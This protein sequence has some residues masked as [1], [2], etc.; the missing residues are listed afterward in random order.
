MHWIDTH[1]HLYDAQFAEDQAAM[2]ARAVAAGVTKMYLPN[3][4]LGSIPGMLAIE[5]AYP[6]HCHAL[7]GLHPCS[8][9][10]SYPTVL[11]EMAAWLTQRPFVAIGEI[12]LDFYWDKTY[13]AEQEAAFLAQLEWAA[14]YNLPIVIHSRESTDRLVELLRA[15][16][17]PGMRGIFHCFGGTM[18]QAE[19]II[20]LGFLLGIGGVLTFK[21]SGLAEVLASIALE[22]LVLETD[23]PYLAPTPHRGKRNESAYLLLVAQKLAEVKQ[24]PL[25][26]VA[27]IT[28][29]TASRLFGGGD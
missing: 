7:M 29:A 4:D 14:Q 24:V 19:Q 16:P 1:A 26:T 8:V 12:G 22:H 15:N 25:A 20:D 13:V 6:E 10:A 2:L 5:T 9:D 27:E 23:A 21:K 28:S 11:A 18:A 17:Y 3:V